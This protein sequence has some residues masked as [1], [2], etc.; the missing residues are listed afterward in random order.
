MILPLVPHLEVRVS[1]PIRALVAL[2]PLLVAACSNV[3]TVDAVVTEQSA[4]TDD[5]LVATWREIDGENV[6]R[7]T[8]GPG[9]HYTVFS[10]DGSDSSQLRARFGRVGSSLIADV[11]PDTTQ[12]YMRSDFGVPVHAIF[13]IESKG[14]S[15]GI[16]NFDADSVLKV[17]AAEKV[18]V[19]YTRIQGDVLLHGDPAGVRNAINGLIAQRFPIAPATWYRRVRAQ[20][21]RSLLPYLTGQ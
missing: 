4:I 13:M 3:F 16:H 10:N 9:S 19:N 21:G 18:R 6:L 14:D 17:L 2:S 20:E 5:R 8:R 15:L 7:I 11:Y 12:K 1:F